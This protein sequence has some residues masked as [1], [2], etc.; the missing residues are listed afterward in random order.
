MTSTNWWLMWTFSTFQALNNM[1]DW[2]VTYEIQSNIYKAII[3]VI[4]EWES[5]GHLKIL[6]KQK[7][8]NKNNNN[9]PYLFCVNAFWHRPCWDNIIHDSFTKAFGDLIE[10]QKV[11]YIIQHLMVPVGVGIHLLKNCGNISKNSCIKKS[12]K[13]RNDEN[14][15][16]IPS[17]KKMRWI[18]V[19]SMNHLTEM[20]L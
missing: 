20:S 17:E 4:C 18:L 15:S 3:Q 7:I 9:N 8:N 14:K 19:K 5:Y 11:P 2:Y 16:T 13:R 10:F 6:L 1:I 12:C